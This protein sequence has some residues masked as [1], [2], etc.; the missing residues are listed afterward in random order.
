MSI[1]FLTNFL[2][3]LL[4]QLIHKLLQQRTRVLKTTGLSNNCNRRFFFS[5]SSQITPGMTL[6]S[7]QFYFTGVVVIRKVTNTY[8]LC[9][10]RRRRR[11]RG[12]DDGVEGPLPS[13]RTVP[14]LAGLHVLTLKKK[15]SSFPFI[16]TGLPYN[17][18]CPY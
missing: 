7:V 14:R 18:N 2:H 3:F 4:H 10:G 8:D 17:S 1:N 6:L 15:F 12:P 13:S 11:G 16:K 5:T 9:D